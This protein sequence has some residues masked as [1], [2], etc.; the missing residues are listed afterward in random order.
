MKPT[1]S[2]FIIRPFSLADAPLLYAAVRETCD[3]L[4]RWMTWCRPDY[5]PAD[6]HSFIL[7]SAQDWQHDLAYFFAA[8]D[9]RDGTL[10]GSVG[11][12]QINR[13][14]QL[15]NLGYWVRSSSTRQGVATQATHLAAHFALQ[16]LGLNRI[17]ILVPADNLPSQRVAQKTGAEFEGVLRKRLILQQ[18]QADALLYS[19]VRK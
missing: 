8:V 6:S 14:H 12:S 3:E 11:I 17:E 2:L 5:S 9:Q 19:I 16:K 1:N 10:L 18:G 15:A 7:R 4:C 13:R